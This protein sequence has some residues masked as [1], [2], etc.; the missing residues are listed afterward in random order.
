MGPVKSIVD[1]GNQ[2]Q[3]VQ[4]DYGRVQDVYQNQSLNQNSLSSTLNHD[5]PKDVAISINSLNF[6]FSSKKIFIENANL[7][8]KMGHKIAF[9]GGSGSGKSVYAKLIA[10]LYSPLSGEILIN[11]VNL[12]SL[13]PEERCK[14][15]GYIGQDNFFFTGSIRENLMLWDNNFSDAEIFT[16]LEQACALDVVFSK[17][18]GLDALLDEGAKNISGGQRQR[19]E[20][21]RTLLLN[22]PILIIDD[23]MSALD[24]DL[25]RKVCE[26]IY[27]R[28]ITTVTIT[29]K[30][31]NMPSF[32]HI[33]LFS[34]GNIIEHGTHLHMMENKD[35]SNYYNSVTQDS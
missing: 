18:E 16:A 10:G 14:S 12:H 1:L 5:A 23:A 19:L 24:P 2:I 3:M 21:A 4:A 13:T 15:V 32:D 35:Y 33:C 17:K 25:D 31:Q 9:I 22:T 6:G 8:F 20:I 29:H 26:H 11:G 28:N 30:I 7:N 27:S 34:G